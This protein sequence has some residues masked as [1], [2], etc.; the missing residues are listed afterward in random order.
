[1]RNLRS[2]WLLVL[3]LLLVSLGC[4]LMSAPDM[5]QVTPQPAVTVENPPALPMTEAEIEVMIDA[6]VEERLAQLQRTPAAY[7]SPQIIET[8]L[9]ETLIGLYEQANPAVVYIIVYG[10]GGTSGSGSGF[11][12]SSEGHIVTNSHV[13]AQGRS[14]EVV[15]Y[16][17][18]RSNATLIGS[19]PD[20][21]LAV[22][23]VEE[24][25]DGIG[26]LP[27]VQ[28]DS[29]Q[30]GQFV[31]AIGNPFGEQGS[32]SLGIV[33]GLGRSLQSQRATMGGST[34]SLPEVIQTDAPINP[35]NSGGPLLNLNGEVVGINAAIAST[36][37]SNSGVGFSIPAAAVRRVVPSLISE[38]EYVY[39]YMGVSF[40]G[41]ITLEEKEVYGLPQLQ[42]AYV[43]SLSPGGPGAV[44]G[45]IAADPSTGKGG[46]LITALDDWPINSFQDLNSFLSF[47]SSPGQTISVRVLRGGQAITLSLTLGERP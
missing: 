13:V 17:G 41:D 23:K 43:I 12:Y 44:A 38:G 1:M 8:D 19:D 35:G 29:L 27:V 7:S 34:Y 18:E 31:I 21:D 9:E 11:V 16:N 30:V 26:T 47:H 3:P 46:D 15:Y 20:S 2:A 40:D 37:G 28:T 10:A 39:P 24:L 14:Y 33:S 32:M 5:V 36:T 45:L 4:G 6:A 42:G 25:P 22:I